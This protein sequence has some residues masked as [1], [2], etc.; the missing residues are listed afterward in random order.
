MWVWGLVVLEFLDFGLYVGCRAFESCFKRVLN[1]SVWGF[2]HQ[3]ELLPRCG[4][5]SM[6]MFRFRSMLFTVQSLALSCDYIW[7]F[8]PTRHNWPQA[9]TARIPIS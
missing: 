9:K 6:M 8:V 1:D 7:V 3:G 2:V 5:S 4:K